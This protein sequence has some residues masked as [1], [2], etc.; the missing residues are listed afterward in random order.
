MRHFL[1]GLVFGTG[2]TSILNVSFFS[3]N[4]FLE[5]SYLRTASLLETVGAT[6][7][8]EKKKQV[9]AK[10]DGFEI[11]NMILPAAATGDGST[12]RFVGPPDHIIERL[13]KRYDWLDT[14]TENVPGMQTSS[15]D[16]ARVA[17][18]E[19]IKS[20]TT[21]SVF[22]DA[23]VSILPEIT[24]PRAKT[25]GP[26]N[27]T[28]RVSGDDWTY[29][30]DTMT[31]WK[32]IDNVHALLKDVIQRNIPGD[33]IETGV[34]RG[35]SSMFARAVILAYSQQQQSL[36][37]RKSFVCDS[38][39]G[40]P[41]AARAL[42]KDDEGY[43]NTPYLEVHEDIVVDGFDKYSLLDE[44]VIF[45]KGFFNDT[46]PQLRPQVDRLAVMR[47]DG[48]M[49]ESTVDALYHLYDKLSV[50]GYVIMDDWF[51]FPSKIACEDFFKV[52]NIQPTIVPIDNLAAYWQKTE[53]VE[54]QYWRYEQ[55]KFT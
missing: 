36:S 47:L 51:G 32:R 6:M 17:Y 15:L 35:G 16:R 27:L 10:G 50:G 53:Q 8:Y 39:R 25:M 33:Y 5:E 24:M 7:K 13:K 42:H 22:L 21:G 12:L 52:H 2:L 1:L 41:P 20:M 55:L 43:D 37:P 48:D 4:F 38:F 46:M 30:G 44:D 54:I 49:Y 19:M 45:V 9:L 29:L 40:L 31:G 11:F 3:N 26:L 23:E 18:L 28:R 34:W 14:I